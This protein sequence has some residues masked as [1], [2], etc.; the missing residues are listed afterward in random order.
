MVLLGHGLAGCGQHMRAGFV[1]RCSNPYRS[2]GLAFQMAKGRLCAYCEPDSKLRLATR[3]AVVEEYLQRE[4]PDVPYR[5]NQQL[6]DRFCASNCLRPN[7]MFD[8]GTHLVVLKVDQ[9]QHK[10]Y[11]EECELVR[12]YTIVETTGLPVRFIRYNPDEFEVDGHAME[13]ARQDRLDI[14]GRELREAFHAAL[15]TTR[16]SVKNLFYNTVEGAAYVQDVSYEVD[17][18]IDNMVA[19]GI[20]TIE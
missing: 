6:P 12:M 15:D 4:F 17:A 13:V 9:D 10:R 3:E 8:M 7:F 18:N 1:N 2:C 11:P 16:M 14:L 19:C 20:I 5:H